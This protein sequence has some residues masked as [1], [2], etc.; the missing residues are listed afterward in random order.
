MFTKICAAIKLA[1]PYGM[2]SCQF[3]QD[4]ITV[5]LKT[6]QPWSWFQESEPLDMPTSIKIERFFQEISYCKKEILSSPSSALYQRISKLQHWM[7]YELPFSSG[8]LE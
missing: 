3:L 5:Q 1:F 4:W 7:Q 2:C 8:N 6:V